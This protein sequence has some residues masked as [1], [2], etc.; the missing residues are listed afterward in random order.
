M[1]CN[2][3]RQPIAVMAC[4]VIVYAEETTAV[5]C[6]WCARKPSLTPRADAL[7]EDGI[8]KGWSEPPDELGI[9]LTVDSGV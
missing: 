3:Q 9:K 2:L 8:G 7:D 5:G 4:A 1:Q 6:E